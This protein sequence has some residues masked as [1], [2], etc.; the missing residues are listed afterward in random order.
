M[1]SRIIR[2]VS[3]NF[4]HKTAAQLNRDGQ[5]C[6]FQE[7]FE[8]ADACWNLATAIVKSTYVR[9][10]RRGVATPPGGWAKWEKTTLRAASPSSDEKEV[11]FESG[12]ALG[13]TVVESIAGGASE[14]GRRRRR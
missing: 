11:P 1:L 10:G 14:T 8:K 13:F 7:V 3:P 9:L 12:E 4:L 2:H 6:E 5:L